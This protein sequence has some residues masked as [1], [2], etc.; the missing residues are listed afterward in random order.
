MSKKGTKIFIILL[1]L[2]ALIFGAYK[3]IGYR[4]YCSVHFQS[5]TTINGVDVSGLTKAETIEALTDAWNSNTFK[6]V[7]GSKV[8]LTLEKPD[9]KYKIS[10]AVSSTMASYAKFPLITKITGKNKEAAFPMKVKYSKALHQQIESLDVCNDKTRIPTENAYVSMKQNRKFEIVPEVYGTNIDVDVLEKA[11][12]DNIA[13]G[14]WTLEYVDSEYYVQ[15]EL[16]KDSQEILDRQA[17]CKNYLSTKITYEFGDETY[18]ISPT[19]FEK[20]IIVKDGGTVSVRKSEIK[21]FIR[22]LA[23]K[24]DTIDNYRSFKSTLRGVV[25]V[26]DGSYGYRIDQ[27]GERKQLIKDIKAGK[28]VSREPVYSLTGYSRSGVNDILGTYVEVDLSNQHLWYYEGGRCVV[29]S[30]FVSG[31]VKE[32]F[33]TSTGAFYLVYKAADVTLKGTNADNTKYESKVKYWMPFY[34]DEGL[35]DASWRSSFG[36]SIYINSGS[37][38][39]VNMPPDKAGQLFNVIPYGC[40]ILVFQ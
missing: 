24:Y 32:G 23:E 17:F 14:K 4:N 28:D 21:K 13:E 34:G 30:P 22:K 9:L 3:Y 39:C 15:P 16:K 6:L 31:C 10:K 20:M 40:P 38:G 1:V 35:H 7:E 27:D 37:H 36:G 25:T 29:S 8:M 19:A 11:V 2:A 12:T 18:T 33:G 26:S 5:D